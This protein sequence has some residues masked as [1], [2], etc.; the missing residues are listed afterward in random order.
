MKLKNRLKI[1][2]IILAISFIFISCKEEMPDNNP[3]LVDLKTCTAI[4]D[5][6]GHI[7]LDLS[8]CLCLSHVLVDRNKILYQKDHWIPLS[9]MRDGYCFPLG[10]LEKILQWAR[11]E[12]KACDAK[13]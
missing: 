2:L 1:H 13:Q 7:T 5:G 3:C 11:E 12:K 9:E 8:S 6:H 4:D 10:Q